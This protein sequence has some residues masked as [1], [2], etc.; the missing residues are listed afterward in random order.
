MRRFSAEAIKNF[1]PEYHVGRADTIHSADRRPQVRFP[2]LRAPH[3]GAYVEEPQ[4]RI[5]AP[6]VNLQLAAIRMLF[7]WLVSGQVLPMN[8]ASAARGLKYSV[9]KGKTPGADR[10]R[11]PG[12][13]STRST[14]RPS[15]AFTTA[16]SF[17]S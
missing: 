17:P 15:L 16:P 9:K 13:F 6:S 1:R 4:E 2:H 14:R 12:S 5:A 11:G 10:R 8:P 7:D 3:I